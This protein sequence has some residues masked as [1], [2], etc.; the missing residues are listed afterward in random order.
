[1][2]NVLQKMNANIKKIK[3]EMTIGLQKTCNGKKK[4]RKK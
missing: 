3:A 1:M 2:T 4:W